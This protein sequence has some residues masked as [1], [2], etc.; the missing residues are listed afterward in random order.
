MN[1]IE[2]LR[3]LVRKLA[4]LL[5]DPQPGLI[6]WHEAAHQLAKEIGEFA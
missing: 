4:A 3:E 1:N 5:A 2:T 6:T